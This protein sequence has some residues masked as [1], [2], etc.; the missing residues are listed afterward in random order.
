[1]GDFFIPGPV[2]LYNT[3]PKYRA[4]SIKKEERL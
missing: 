3:T 4:T 1:M 2:Y